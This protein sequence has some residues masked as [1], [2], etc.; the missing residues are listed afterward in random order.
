MTEQTEQTGQTG[1]VPS[2]LPP[3]PTFQQVYGQ[4]IMVKY[5]RMQYPSRRRNETGIT[6]H[7]QETFLTRV[8][9]THLNVHSID[10]KG[11]KDVDDA[12]SICYGSDRSIVQLYVHICDPTSWI[13]SIQSSVFLC[14]AKNG[15][16]FYPSGDRTRRMFTIPLR[17]K[18]SFISGT[19]NALTIKYE[20]HFTDNTYQLQSVSLMPSFI[21]C[22][23]FNNYTYEEAASAYRGKCPMFL[24]L[25]KLTRCLKD[26]L[27]VKNSI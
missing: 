8:N 5:P 17:K 14:A 7:F 3:T 16:S 10:P 26:T 6:Q 27:S 2:S 11:S 23:I 24:L 19:K 9:L 13:K 4:S 15:T 18:S 20:F 21:V 1:N 25:Q 12:F 22:R